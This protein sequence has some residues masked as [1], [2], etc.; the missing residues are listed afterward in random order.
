MDPG[1]D[2]SERVRL[3]KSV[4]LTYSYAREREGTA[5]RRDSLRDG[6]LYGS[7]G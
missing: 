2:R 3:G 4:F 6:I 5:Y 1:S 7:G